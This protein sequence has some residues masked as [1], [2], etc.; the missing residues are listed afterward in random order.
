MPS[1]AGLHTYPVKSC[2][3]IA[4]R[5]AGLATTGFL[6]DRR[7]MIVRAD[8]D[9]ARFLTQRDLPRLALI[10]TALD[11]DTL[12]LT[13]PGASPLTIPVARDGNARNVVVWRDTLSALD[14]G[15][16]AAEWLSAHVG[17]SV[18]LV[19][20]DDA[21]AHRLCNR[22]F[23]GDS[24]AHTMFADGYPILVIGSASLDDLNARLVEKGHDALP[25]NRFR[26]N[27]V[28]DGLEAFDEDHIAELR[29]GNVTLRLVKPCT[30]CQITTTDQTTAA[31]EEEP[32][33][34][35]GGYRFD[36]RFDGISFG[37]NAIVVQGAGS[38]LSIGDAVEIGWNF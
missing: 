22:Q 17:L 28:L 25:M 5:R 18:R 35:L 24:G 15:D 1:I 4:H 34:T 23:A 30:R 3:G 36:P 20:F 14:Q 19:R 8:G 13:A 27:V 21:H 12:T 2:R 37:M 10:A 7:W 31:V 26:P 16:A 38:S 11:D 9:P 29:T 32:L 6:H 33:A